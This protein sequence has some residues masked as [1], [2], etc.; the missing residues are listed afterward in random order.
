MGIKEG[1]P[2]AG[3]N[4][5]FT[6]GFDPDI[7]FP[8]LDTMSPYR[9]N[10]LFLTVPDVV[11]DAV[12][13]V[14]L[15]RKWA[16]RFHGWPLA[17]VAQDGIDA[18]SIGLWADEEMEDF[19]EILEEEGDLYA[20]EAWLRS[21]AYVPWSELD[22]LFVGGTTEWKESPACLNVIL[23]ARDRGKHIHIGRVNWWRR[24]SLFRQVIGSENFTCD[25]TRQRFDGLDNAKQA[26]LDYQNRLT[27]GLW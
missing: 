12:G 11:G 27:L 20:V 16:G 4:Q 7:F 19:T 24:Y 22:C 5:A 8:W 25:G 23:Q 6:Q 21:Q 18:N 13:T 1:A 14:N 26:W 2:W 3:D 15:W 10:C 9:D 17:F